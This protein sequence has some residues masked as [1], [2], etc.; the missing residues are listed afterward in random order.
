MAV[1]VVCKFVSFNPRGHGEEGEVEGSIF[2]LAQVDSWLAIVVRRLTERE[3]RESQ[4]Q[5]L[6]A[7]THE[8]C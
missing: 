1:L 5:K 8:R 7:D 4:R 6:C 2:W 3:T